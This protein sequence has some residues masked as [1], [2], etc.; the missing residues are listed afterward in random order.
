MAL[1][2]DTL[3]SGQRVVRE[4]DTLVARQGRPAMV[5]GDN[6]TVLASMLVLSWCQR[7]GVEWHYVAP[8]KPVQKGFVESFN[9]RLRDE[10]LND[11][12]FSTL[13][14]ARE[15]IRS[16][17]YDYNHHR[18]H[19]GLG[20]IPPAEFMTQNGAGNARRVALEVNSRSFRMV[21]AEAW[22]KSWSKQRE[23]C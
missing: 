17:Q 3:L 7:T 22:P 21:G 23:S 5:V 20:N 1:V 10:L 12:L 9:G 18:P 4:L 13:G 6:C 14:E 19:S 11:T 2:A 16:W 8:G 15:R